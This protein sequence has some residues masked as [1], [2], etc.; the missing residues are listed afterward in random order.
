M[1]RTAILLG[2]AD[3]GRDPRHHEIRAG[4]VRQLYVPGPIG[5]LVGRQAERVQREAGLADAAGTGQR[6]HPRRGHELPQFVELVLA[7]DEAVRFGG[8]I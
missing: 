6:H 7:A 8:E 1:E 4:N 5:E 3:H 2:H